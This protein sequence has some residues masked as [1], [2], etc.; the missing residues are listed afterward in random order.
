MRK[1]RNEE[2]IEYKRN[3]SAAERQRM[4][5]EDAAL[6]RHREALVRRASRGQVMSALDERDRITSAEFKAAR[7]RRHCLEATELYRQALLAAGHIQ[8][9]RKA[10]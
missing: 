1:P 2:V 8:P 10:A 3:L 7:L 5:A 6:A 4:A 9:E